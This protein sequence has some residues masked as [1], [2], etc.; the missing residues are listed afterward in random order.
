MSESA[1]YLTAEV[2]YSRVRR[3]NWRLIAFWTGE[4][5][6][7]ILL[8]RRSAQIFMGAPDKC[9]GSRVNLCAY[10]N[11]IDKAFVVP[12]WVEV[13]M[14]LWPERLVIFGITARI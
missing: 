10:V 9:W 4:R 3:Y 5:V 7:A 14:I 1:W 8:S 6:G 12:D 2:D 13:E 11:F